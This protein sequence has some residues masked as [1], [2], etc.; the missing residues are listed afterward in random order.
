MENRRPN[1]K[2]KIFSNALAAALV[3]IFSWYLFFT[4]NPR[5]RGEVVAGKKCMLQIS[6]LATG[7]E[8]YKTNYQK[9]PSSIATQLWKELSGENP[10]KIIFATFPFGGIT[11]NGEYLDPWGSPITIHFYSTNSYE[12]SSVGK[13]KISGSKDDIVFNS[14]SN[15]F[16]NP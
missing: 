13:D 14:A 1:S 9:Y 4:I 6:A 10:G 12:I 3:I 15:A 5:P 8:S 7:I 16:V 11:T 2:S